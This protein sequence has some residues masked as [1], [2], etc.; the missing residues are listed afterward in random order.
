MST[1]AAEPALRVPGWERR[2]WEGIKQGG[3]VGAAALC[4]ALI[5]EWGVPEQTGR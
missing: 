3:F 5:E 4:L 1:P 2:P